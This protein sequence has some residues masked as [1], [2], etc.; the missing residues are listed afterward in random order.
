VLS[1]VGF[2]PA[3]D[4]RFAMIVLVDEPRTERWGSEAAA[5]VFAAIGREIIRSMEIPPRDTPPVQIVTGPTE[6]ST[7]LPI[8]LVSTAGETVMPNLKGRALRSALA[9]LEPL[10]LRVT[11]TGRGLVAQQTPAPGVTVEPGA[12]ARLQL[13]PPSRGGR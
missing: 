8:R 10:G 12:T 3:D 5:P 6:S 9:A 7:E 11:V 4:P 13:T 1:F 2:A